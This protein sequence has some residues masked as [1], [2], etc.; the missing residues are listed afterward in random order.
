MYLM[1]EERM[2]LIDSMIDWLIASVTSAQQVFSSSLSS[3]TGFVD[4]TG[5][6]HCVFHCRGN[7]K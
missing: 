4:F 2:I 5:G 6:K 7:N 1:V 3:T